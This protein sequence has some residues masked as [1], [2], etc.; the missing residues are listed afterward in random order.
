MSDMRAKMIVTAI[1]PHTN[2]DGSLAAETLKMSAVSKSDGYGDDGLDEDNT[3][4]HFSPS[5]SFEM[6][7]ANEA[8][9]GK[10][11]IGEKY[12]LDFTKAEP[13]AKTEPAAA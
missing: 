11:E 4:S 8:L 3:F 1:E 13:V 9:H 5:G 6:Y 2:D 12:Y 7:I 10:F